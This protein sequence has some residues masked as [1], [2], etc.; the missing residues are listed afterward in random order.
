MH[1][2]ENLLQRSRHQLLNW[3]SNVLLKFGHFH[4][5]FFCLTG[6]ENMWFRSFELQV[7]QSFHLLN[8]EKDDQYPSAGDVGW[9]HFAFWPL[10]SCR[11]DSTTLQRDFVH[12]QYKALKTV[13]PL[14]VLL[15]CYA[16]LLC[17]LGCR[18]FG[19]NFW[20]LLPQNFL[21]ECSPRVNIGWIGWRFKKLS[22]EIAYNKGSHHLALVHID[23]QYTYSGIFWEYQYA[24]LLYISPPNPVLTVSFFSIPH[25]Q[26]TPS[27]ASFVFLGPWLLWFASR[28]CHQDDPQEETC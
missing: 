3:I 26:V 16:G 2:W 4:R 9:I 20:H 8:P 5:T 28:S 1:H 19:S 23:I 14:L 12:T 11:F 15:T 27:I 24:L 7:L 25:Q 10:T 13:K 17:L 22:W 21:G 6:G 18:M